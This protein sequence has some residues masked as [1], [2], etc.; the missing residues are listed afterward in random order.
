MTSNDKILIPIIRRVLPKVIAEQI[1]GVQPMDWDLFR[2]SRGRGTHI[3]K[4]PRRGVW[5]SKEKLNNFLRLNNR[6]RTH[7]I[8]ELEAAGYPSVALDATTIINNYIEHKEWL[9]TNLPHQHF[10]FDSLHLY[11]SDEKYKTMY[12]L[13]WG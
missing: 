2:H 13:R 8:Q 11:F 10:L 5:M 12:L 6:H 7:T 4:L 3:K 9:N 1:A